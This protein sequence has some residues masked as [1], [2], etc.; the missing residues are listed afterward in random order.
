M[1]A[2]TL[3]LSPIERYHVY[4]GKAEIL[5][6]ELEHPVKQELEK[7]G[8]VELD[9]TRRESLLTN[10]V[11]PTN[12]QGLI[13]FKSGHTRVAGTQVMQKTDIFGNDHSG[14]VTLSTATIEGYNVVDTVTADRVVAQISTEHALVH[15]HV[16][17]VH[18]IGTRFEGL[19]IG[20]FEVP[21]EL[22]LGFCG[23]KPDED[24][25]YLED[26]D[27]LDK[28]E[29]Q[30]EG[31]RDT[32]GVPDGVKKKYKAEI[33]YIDNLR[34]RAKARAKDDRN[35]YPKLRCSLIKTIGEIPIP[36]VKTFGN[37][38]FIPNFGTVALATLEVG[39]RAD[40]SDFR[41]RQGD[42]PQTPSE[43]S[44]YFTLNMFEMNLGCPVG[45]K[46]KGPGVS[47]NG[48]SYP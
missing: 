27:F 25:P 35:G 3:G 7:F 21:V 28:V 41:H 45:G 33:E 5:S 44:N 26:G 38:I 46:T 22:D 23:S 24:R 43:P 48:Q 1:A 16:P 9:H 39:M 14:W 42:R 17:K 12:I 36:G 31:V 34:K 8:H 32:K 2:K 10:S 18:F 11:G 19:R 47:G 29:R 13:S 40:Q 30:F 15:G 6:G 20:G 37:V 4:H